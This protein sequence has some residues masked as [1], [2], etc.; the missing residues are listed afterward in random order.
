MSIGSRHTL[1]VG[2]L[3]TLCLAALVIG[4]MRPVAHAAEGDEVRQRRLGA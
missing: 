4:E 3:A 2:T 1:T